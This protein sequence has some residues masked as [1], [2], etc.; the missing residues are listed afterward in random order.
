M[1]CLGTSFVFLQGGHRPADMQQ[2]VHDRDITQ[3]RTKQGD[4]C[5][6]CQDSAQGPGVQVGHRLEKRVPAFGRTTRTGSQSSGAIETRKSSMSGTLG[7]RTDGGEGKLMS[8][9]NSD[10]KHVRR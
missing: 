3:N 1:K 4:L 10:F 5:Q 8:T 7:T 9:S 2:P 6:H